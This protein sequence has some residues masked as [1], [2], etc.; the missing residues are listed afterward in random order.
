MAGNRKMNSIRCLI[1]I[2]LAAGGFF[3]CKLGTQPSTVNRRT[4]YKYLIPNEVAFT[5][6]GDG[7]S[8]QIQFSTRED[9]YCEIFYYSQDPSG[10]PSEQAPVRSSCSGVD[11]PRSEFNETVTGIN[12]ETVYNFG[13]FV[14]TETDTKEKGEVLVIRESTGE[15]GAVRNRNGEYEEI[16]MARFNAPLR[17]AEIQRARLD[18]PMTA[19]DIIGRSRSNLGC[20]PALD[21][22][23]WT[24]RS[25]IGKGGL[26]SLA[27]RGFATGEATEKDSRLLAVFNALQFGNP[28]W[29]WTYRTPD[30]ENV[31]VK[32]RPPAR[33]TSVEVSQRTRTTLPEVKLSDAEAFIPLDPGYPL[34]VAW[35]WEN[36][37]GNAF[38]HLRIGKAGETGS[39]YCTFDP[40]AGRA[41]VEPVFFSGLPPGKQSLVLELESLV[42]HATTGWF[43][44]SID[45]RSIK[46]EKS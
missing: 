17:T 42:F 31:L 15:S 14:W 39:L 26:A 24:S 45:W 20:S 21:E 3:G 25:G 7:T 46:L 32:I 43:V 11:T 33:L 19:S 9:A 12:A 29:E 37:P 28:E 8:V 36:L 5:R 41:S 40:K 23:T 44:R 35:Q 16:L 22:L 27:M 4:S 2:I 6:L 18:P 30:R 1:G 13:I 38:I 34:T 10:L